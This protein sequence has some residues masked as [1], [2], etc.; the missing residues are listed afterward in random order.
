MCGQ[1]RYLREVVDQSNLYAVQN[2]KET[3]TL[4]VPKLMVF[5]GKTVMTYNIHTI[6]VIQI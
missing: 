3:S 5:S 4:T 1:L 6:Q 2:G